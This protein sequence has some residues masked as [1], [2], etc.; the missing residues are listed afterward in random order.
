MLIL[1]PPTV[2]FI[3]Y[4]SNKI[5]IYKLNLRNTSRYPRRITILQPSKAYFEVKLR[6]KDLAP[7]EATEVYVV[8]NPQREQGRIEDEFSL[9]VESEGIALHVP[10]LCQ[11]KAAGRDWSSKLILPAREAEDARAA[12]G[13]YRGRRLAM[14]PNR[15]LA[16]RQSNFLEYKQFCMLLFEQKFDR[17][18]G[19]LELKRVKNDV[20]L[21]EH[22]LDESAS[23]DITQY[24]RRIA[25]SSLRAVGR[26][27]KGRFAV[28]YHVEGPVVQLFSGVTL[29]WE[30]SRNSPQLILRNGVAKMQEEVRKIVV[31]FRFENIRYHFSYFKDYRRRKEEAGKRLRLEDYLEQLRRIENK[32]PPPMGMELDF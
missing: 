9:R 21:G 2:E 25:E 24:C 32:R 18:E 1:D 28:E 10:I 23:G 29:E 15:H 6:S 11:Y 19:Y 4:P 27:V 14:V 12:R 22:P 16:E 26:V 13:P 3:D 30:P 31:N 17:V 20:Y 8:F 5:S 7:K